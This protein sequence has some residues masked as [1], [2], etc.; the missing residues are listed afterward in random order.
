VSPCSCPVLCF[1]LLYSVPV[2]FFFFFFDATVLPEIYALSL[3]DAL[4]IFVLC[5]CDCIFGH[6]YPRYFRWMGI[7]QGTAAANPNIDPD[8]E[9]KY[10]SAEMGENSHQRT[11]T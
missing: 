8:D 9:T 1:S 5:P 4:P 7:R 10:R 3:H 6:A 11:F 2:F